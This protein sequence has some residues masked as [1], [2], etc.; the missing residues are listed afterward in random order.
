MTLARTFTPPVVAFVL[1]SGGEYRAEHLTPVVTGVLRWWPADQPLDVLLLTDFPGVTTPLREVLALFPGAAATTLTEV[2]LQYG[3][4]G[5]WSKLEL[6]RPDLPTDR[7]LLY[8]DIDT[9]FVG[10]LNTVAGPRT[11]LVML[12]D[13]YRPER[14]ASGMM[15]LPAWARPAIWQEWQR[16][17]GYIR[18]RGD[19][20]ALAR[21]L[22][23]L[24][25]TPDRWQTV[26][27]GRVVSYKV[28][29]RPTGTVPDGASVVCF[30]G[31]PRPWRVT[32]PE[33]VCG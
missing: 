5:W 3:W 13:F 32:L 27:P 22:Q 8:F 16:R 14:P 28:H 12:S 23:E 7:D 31:A 30:H 4:P 11:P 25:V 29:V 26:A 15:Y 2:P 19:Q 24:R 18:E 9:R 21:I 33:L 1:R 10:P 17:P 20:E 6:F